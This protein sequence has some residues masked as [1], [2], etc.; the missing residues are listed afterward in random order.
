MLEYLIEVQERLLFVTT[1]IKSIHLNSLQ[2]TTLSSLI[3]EDNN[4]HIHVY[5][6]PA[7][8]ID[9]RGNT[10]LS[11]S[12]TAFTLIS[13]THDAILVDAAITVV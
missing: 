13:G 5:H 4:L 1:S 6:P 3:Y 11:I 7:E 8:P 12:L 2:L 9:Y 10:S